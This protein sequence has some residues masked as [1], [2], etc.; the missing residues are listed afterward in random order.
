MQ[1]APGGGASLFE[2]PANTVRAAPSPVGSAA[3][4]SPAL[5]TALTVD[6][7]SAVAI[8]VSAAE[9]K[10]SRALVAAV[11]AGLAGDSAADVSWAAL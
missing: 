11:L 8:A 1:S 9:T 10:E 3:P 7:K 6:S 5:A 4:V 2:L